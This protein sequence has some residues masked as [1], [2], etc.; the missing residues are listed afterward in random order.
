MPPTTIVKLSD[1]P[2]VYDNV[3]WK[4]STEDELFIVW[5]SSA[6][7]GDFSECLNCNLSFWAKGIKGTVSHYQMFDRSWNVL[8]KKATYIPTAEWVGDCYSGPGYKQNP[9]W[10]VKG[11][12]GKTARTY[13]ELC[14]I[15]PSIETET[16]GKTIE[17]VT[18]QWSCTISGT[19]ETFDN[20]I[21]FIRSSYKDD[22]EN[23][24]NFV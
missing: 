12:R 5:Y 6:S 7:G 13:W 18:G 1:D 9:N 19:P 11:T 14:D 24:V 2:K 23:L 22:L 3:I 20:F 10:A 4:Q 8:R 16:E 21:D 15:V 17:N